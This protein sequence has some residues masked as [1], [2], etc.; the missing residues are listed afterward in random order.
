MPVLAA[1]FP[2]LRLDAQTVT[3]ETPPDTLRIQAEWNVARLQPRDG[4]LTFT[5]SRL[6]RRDDGQLVVVVGRSDLSALLDVAGTRV[7][8]P[9]H[10][11]PLDAGDNEVR[12]YLAR[13][14]GAWLEMGRFQLR[15]LDRA[16]FESLAMRPTLDVQSSGQLHAHGTP[17]ASPN[18]GATGRPDTYQDLALNGGVDGALARDGWAMT[19]QGLVAGATREQARLRAAQLGPRAPEVDLASYAIHATRGGLAIDAGHLSLGD[20]HLLATQFR[21]RGLSASLALPH[22]MQLGVAG[23]AASE[24]VG[25]DDP[26]GIARP[27]HRLVLGTFGF[28]VIPSHPGLLHFALSALDGAR[29]PTTSFQQGA[30]TDREESRGA[31][32]QVTAADPG[33]RTHLTVGFARSRFTNPLEPALSA[34]APLV[35]VRPETRGAQ[36]GELRVDV[37]RD[38][39][40]G[41][42]P[43]TLAVTARH[44]RVDPEFR[45]IGAATLQADRDEDVVE[46]NGALDALQLQYSLSRARDNL[47]HISSLLTTRTHTHTLNAAL[48]VA[49]L[50]RSSPGAWWWPQAT[51]SWLVMEQRGDG[52]PPDGGF[53][54]ASQ[55]PNQHTGNVTT[56]LA[57][58]RAV[59]SVALHYNRAGVDNRQPDGASTNL[60]TDVAGATLALTMTPTFTLSTDLSSETVHDVV[61]ASRAHTRRIGAQGDWRPVGHTAFTGTLSLAGNEDPSATRRAHNV[62]VQLEVSQ[63]FNVYA[64]PRDGSQARLF[65]RYTLSDAQ[66]RFDQ[67]LQPTLR[68]WGMNGGFSLRLF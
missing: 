55:V 12:A 41:S 51:A 49:Q 65:L 36:F 52:I 58:Q 14:D 53:R 6:P 47:A 25:W 7:R 17:G 19:V 13:T 35:D 67:T 59:G 29:Q 50:L 37:L 34:G 31:G 15:L 2:L 66:L 11:Q 33:G 45:S 38:A 63:G 64:R 30:V 1:A 9:L 68:Q 32:A 26:F 3:G 56:A 20:D 22:G 23:T 44:Q 46:T 8:V 48:P 24:I 16:G 43:T 28:E 54:L 10:G 18:G 62:D 4:Q 21:S 61:R 27:S 42:A 57:W 60:V 40:L 5:L 39:H